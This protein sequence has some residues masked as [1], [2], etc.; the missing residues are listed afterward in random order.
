MAAKKGLMTQFPCARGRAFVCKNIGD[1]IQ[2][3]ATRQYIDRIDEYVEQEEADQYFPE[4]GKPIRLI[5]N[6]W[7]QWRSKNWPPSEYIDPLLISMHISPLKADDLLTPEG[8]AFLKKY[9]PVGCRDYYTK[10]LLESVGVPAY[11]SACMTLTLGKNYKV[12]AEERR[13][14]YIVDPYFPI[15]ELYTEKDGEICIN[16]ELA[17]EVFCFYLKNKAVID[18]LARKEFFLVYSP[19]GFLDRDHS[20]YRAIYKAT[21]FY[22]IYSQKFDDELLLEAEYITHWMDVDMSGKVSN[23][24]LLDIAESLVKKYASAKLVITSRIHAA[25]PCLGLDT[26]VVFIANDEVI[27]ESGT[28]NTPGRLGG[29]I[30]FFRVLNLENDSFS[31]N[32]EIFEQITT[33]AINTT[34]SNKQAWRIYAEQLDQKASEFMR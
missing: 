25:L 10:H 30:D 31:T 1:Y 12:N 26:P 18:Q 29:L 14:V 21:L 32:D 19:T 3:V 34:F 17:E 6:G 9:S 22:K 20:L 7:F 13:G 28:F 4:D 24:D 8:I 27:S 16:K 33:F 2:A 5:M 11:F 23:D 15:P